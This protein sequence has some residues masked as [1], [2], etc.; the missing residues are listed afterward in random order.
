M[1]LEFERMLTLDERDQFEMVFEDLAEELA[2][3]KKSQRAI[4][5]KMK[6]L[7]EQGSAIL[8][9]LKQPP[10]P[11]QENFRPSPSTSL[12]TRL[13][14]TQ[15]CSPLSPPPSSPPIFSEAPGLSLASPIHLRGANNSPP[16]PFVSIQY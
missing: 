15:P 16:P 7:I 13:P 14:S 2:R 4:F 8:N 1:S 11:N 10:L 6:A 3:L 5:Q 9:L 12:W